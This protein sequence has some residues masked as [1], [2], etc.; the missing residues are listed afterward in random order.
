MSW[1]ASNLQTILAI[2]DGV[3]PAGSGASVVGPAVA[4]LL[5]AVASIVS[6][7]VA[8]ST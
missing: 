7:S 2:V 4:P 6:E 3:G 8:I 5:Q 1:M